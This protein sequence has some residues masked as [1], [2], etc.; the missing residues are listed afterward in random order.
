[1]LLALVIALGIIVVPSFGS[2]AA[3][4]TQKYTKIVLS[5]NKKT[6]FT[7]TVTEK[8]KSKA[9]T[10]LNG[11]FAGMLPKKIAL[12]AVIDD[13]KAQITSDGKKVYVEFTDTKTKKP[14][15]TYINENAKTKHVVTIKFNANAKKVVK[16]LSLAKNGKY[17]YG[18]KIGNAKLKTFKT[19]KGYFFF[20]AYGSERQGYIKNGVLYVKG[21]IVKSQF[22]KKLIKQ[23]TVKSAKLVKIAK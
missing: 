3:G 21:D 15:Q 16:A 4:K 8:N 7:F 23:K 12:N 18:I 10:Q 1:M 11:L 5:S 22:V 14:I 2:E 13:R 17:T 9:A 6:D 20:K 19:K